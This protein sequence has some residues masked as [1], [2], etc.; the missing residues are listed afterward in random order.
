M[1]NDPSY[2]YL[3]NID[4]FLS[5]IVSIRMAYQ[6]HSYPGPTASYI[7][8]AWKEDKYITDTARPSSGYFPS[9]KVLL[10]PRAHSITASYAWKVDDTRA[11][12]YTHWLITML[13]LC[14]FLRC[15]M[16]LGSIPKRSVLDQVFI[17]DSQIVILGVKILN[18]LVGIFLK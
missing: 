8:H 7:Y 17:H 15:H 13:L 12:D 14:C 6:W 18:N 9:S 2:R 4:S 10:T 5:I 11:R 16:S 3:S 1:E